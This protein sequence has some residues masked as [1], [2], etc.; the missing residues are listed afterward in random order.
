MGVV[1]RLFM[2]SYYT[3]ICLFA[4]TLRGVDIKYTAW[5]KKL[6]HTSS[7]Q[8]TISIFCSSISVPVVIV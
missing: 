3:N 8:S 2:T 1:E 4:R 6:V 5:I 7:L